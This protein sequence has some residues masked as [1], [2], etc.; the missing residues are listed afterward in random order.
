[1][2]DEE[3]ISLFF[4]RNERA[5]SETSKKYGAY[6][7][8]IISNVLSDERDVNECENDTYFKLWRS[9][10]PQKPGILSAFLAKT[11]RNCAIDR[12]RENNADK[13]GGNNA[14]ISIEELGKDV[15]DV[16]A[17]DIDTGE[18]AKLI[19]SFLG[20]QKEMNRNIFIRRYFYFD[21]VKTIA[22]FYSVSIAKVK[23]SLFRT[24]KALASYLADEGYGVNG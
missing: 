20:K 12:Y 2:E 17:D 24:R 13:R 14:Q 3:I 18:L 16:T 11:A 21:D 8:S 4:D 15:A 22:A 6:V 10:P 19:D 5:V 1:M 9:I 23:S 7:R